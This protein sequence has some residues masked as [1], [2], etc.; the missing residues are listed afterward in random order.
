LV[1]DKQQMKIIPKIIAINILTISLGFGVV[2]AAIPT[3]VPTLTVGDISPTG[4]ANAFSLKASNWKEYI[5]DKLAYVAAKQVLHQMTVSVVNWINTG[6]KGKPAFLT[7][8]TGFFLDAADQITGDFLADSGP[9]K[10][11]CSPWSIEIRTGLAFQQLQSTAGGIPGQQ[12]Y[13]CTLGAVINSYRGA[14]VDGA[15]IDGF[16]RGDFNQGGWP[17]FIALTTVDTNN[18]FGTYLQAR[19]DQLYAIGRRQNSISTDLQQG[20][21]FLSWENCTDLPDFGPDDDF[22]AYRGGDPSI[23]R[24]SNGSAQRCTSNT[25]GSVIADTL[26]DSLGVPTQELLL[27][28][29]INSIVS[30]LISQLVTQTLQKGLYTMSSGRSGPGSGRQYLENVYAGAISQTTVNTSILNSTNPDIQQL[31]VAKQNYDD[32]LAAIIVSIN[33][34]NT[35]QNCFTRKYT[36]ITPDKTSEVSTNISL[37]NNELFTNVNPLY[38]TISNRQGA[39]VNRLNQ[40]QTVTVN[41]NNIDALAQTIQTQIDG[42][43]NFI[44]GTNVAALVTSSESDL[45]SVITQ[46]DKF[47][48][49]ADSFLTACN[50]L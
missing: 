29:N 32:A 22:E 6:F 19:S 36:S 9:L 16:I 26:R 8:P 12:R 49:D 3:G 7:N 42:L 25:P 18:P 43:S 20:R 48:S 38:S 28:D 31:N 14:Y 27:A 4:I 50:R 15:S 35:A 10:R 5:G 30:A 37:I 24:G 44:S 47:N 33:K 21:G 40:P 17:A 13:T 11:L 41:T 2:H 34:Y 1:H 46:T 39:I 23:K 45:T